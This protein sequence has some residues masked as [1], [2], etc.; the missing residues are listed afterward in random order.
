MWSMNCPAIKKVDKK[1]Y[2]RN[3]S[4]SPVISSFP[5]R[6]I[7]PRSLEGS[8]SCPSQLRARITASTTEK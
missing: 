8:E 4:A 7:N 3:P 6:R 1:R 2:T 5:S